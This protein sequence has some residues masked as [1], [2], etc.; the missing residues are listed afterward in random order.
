MFKF[1][2]VI[3][4]LVANAL[5]AN[6][7][8]FKVD[9]V[10]IGDN[11]NDCTTDCFMHCCYNKEEGQSSSICR[12]SSS[13]DTTPAPCPEKSVTTGEPSKRKEWARN[14]DNQCYQSG[15]SGQFKRGT[16]KP[17][18][19]ICGPNPGLRFQQKLRKQNKK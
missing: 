4:A 14:N 9:G 7:S 19:T 13:G 17:R 2:A 11:N 12:L 10:E 8:A 5:V 3:F 16:P 18:L 6:V 1:T 15:L